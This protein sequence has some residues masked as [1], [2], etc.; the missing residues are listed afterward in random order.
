[1]SDEFSMEVVG[2]KQALST[3][4]RLDKDARKQVNKDYRR[5]V[6]PVVRDARARIPKDPPL[7]GFKY[8]MR[9]GA[10]EKP[11]WT[12]KEKGAVRP[13]VSGKKPRTFGAY[14]SSLGVF[15]VRWGLPTAALFDMSSNYR[16]QQGQ[17][18]IEVLNRTFGSPSRIMW[19]AWERTHNGVEQGMRELVQRVITQANKELK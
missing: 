9:K 8:P 1:M 5:I 11:V 15:G 18:M 14:T 16:T 19:K 7:S 3:L 4:N 12:G 17:S 2:L 10:N 6:D 13:Y